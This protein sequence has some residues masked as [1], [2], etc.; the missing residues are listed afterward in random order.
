MVLVAMVSTLL[1]TLLMLTAFG[2]LVALALTISVIHIWLQ[3]LQS[4]VPV[5]LT[6]LMSMRFRKTD[7]GLVIGQYIRARKAGFGLTPAQLEDHYLADGRVKETIDALIDSRNLDSPLTWEEAVVFDHLGKP[8]EL[9][10]EAAAR[11]LDKLPH[12]PS[13]PASG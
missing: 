2:A 7:V 5:R 3:A 8:D 11:Q 12:T 1:Y 9:P 4:G 10:L 13:P 6:E